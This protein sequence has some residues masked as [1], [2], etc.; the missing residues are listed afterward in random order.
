RRVRRPA[1]MG[2]V[3]I[4]HQRPQE[5]EVQH[6]VDLPEDVVLWHQHLQ[7]DGL[8]QPQLL[9]LLTLHPDHLTVLLDSKGPKSLR[10][11]RFFHMTSSAVRLE[12]AAVRP[13]GQS[14]SG[15]PLPASSA[16]GSGGTKDTIC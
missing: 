1:Q 9:L 7:V 6:P 10:S 12:F 16:M 4:R 8:P 5:G 11:E 13:P 14:W 15:G 2:M 3:Q